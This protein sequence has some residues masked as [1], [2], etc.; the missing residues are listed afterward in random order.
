M[1]QIHP[2][3]FIEEAHF[4]ITNDILW[5]HMVIAQ[6]PTIELSVMQESSLKKKPLSG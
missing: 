5:L 1:E 6:L 4:T 3:I 2:L